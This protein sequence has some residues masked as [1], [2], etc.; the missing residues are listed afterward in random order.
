MSDLFIPHGH[1][2][3]WNTQLVGLHLLSDLTIAIAYFSIPLTLFYFV[4]QREDLPFNWIFTLF[5]AFIVLCGTTHLLEVW[6]LWHPVYWLSGSVKAM[7]ANRV[8]H[9]Q[10]SCW[11]RLIPQALKLPSPA[12]LEAA[13]R[14][15]QQQ[16]RNRELAEAHIQQL[17]E[18]LE[19]RVAAR[20]QELAD[21][22]NQ[23]SDL[24]ERLSL[25]IESAGL[26]I[27]DWNITAK[28]LSGIVI[29]KYCSIIDQGRSLNTL[30]KIGS[31][32][33]IPT[34]SLE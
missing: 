25:A 9:T 2:Y 10:R 29:T 3:L 31:V 6:T 16:I 34:T 15:L 11:C 24:A 30:T 20:T 32:A 33:C 12:Q 8:R 13:N 5:G 18:D 19:A 14:E 21:S 7:T 4:E 22:M 23:A 26:G 28:K 1:C 27:C 17:N